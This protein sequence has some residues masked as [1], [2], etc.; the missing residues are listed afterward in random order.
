MRFV[1]ECAPS[2]GLILSLDV[3][4]A[5]GAAAVRDGA[6]ANALAAGAVEIVRKQRLHD[7]RPCRVHLFASGPNG[8]M[9]HLG[10]AGR[11]LGRTTIYE[12]DFDNP[13]LGYVP[14]ITCPPEE[15]Q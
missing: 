6:H 12:Y 8:L 9:F 7:G 11:A 5:I 3:L 14:S 13:H 4:P 10:R 1:T 2:V 15:T